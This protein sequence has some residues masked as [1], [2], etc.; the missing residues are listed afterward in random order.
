MLQIEKKNAKLNLQQIKY[1]K[2]KPGKKSITQNDL[3]KNFN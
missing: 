3:R 2:M 1:Q